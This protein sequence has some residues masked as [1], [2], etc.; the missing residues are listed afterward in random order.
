MLCKIL[1]LFIYIQIVQKNYNLTGALYFYCSNVLL[2]NFFTEL[3][4]E[5]VDN[6]YKPEKPNKAAHQAHQ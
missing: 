6:G 1:F 3:S 4:T 2:S 5:S